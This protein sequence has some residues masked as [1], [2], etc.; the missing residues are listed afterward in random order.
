M[1]VVP[2]RKRYFRDVARMGGLVWLVCLAVLTAF[3]AVEYWEHRDD[4][5]EELLEMVIL[6]A[7]LA[8]AAPLVAWLAWRTSGKLLA[9]LHG[10]QRTVDRIRR[11]E[12]DAQ[13]AAGGADDELAELLESVNGAFEAHRR[14][15]ER[16]ERFS[17]DVSHQ[18]R[19]PLTA[20]R[21]EGE[22]CLGRERTPEAYRDTLG[23]LLEQADRLAKVVDQLLL[24]AK[25][26]VAGP[27]PE[28]RPVDLEGLTWEVADAFRPMCED[29]GAALELEL[30]PVA[31]FGNP[32]WLREAMN[33]LFNNALEY[34]PDPARFRVELRRA[35]DAAEWS[36]EDSGPGIPLEWRERIFDRFQR[37][38]D[39]RDGGS[40][41]GLAIVREVARAHG[42]DL[43][44]EDGALGG[45]RFVMRV[46][47]V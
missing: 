29:R 25:V 44:L 34:T 3:N 47:V 20:M 17:A 24:L 40:G 45:C 38:G 6:F 22:V 2:L 33:N 11:G 8:A 4:G 26:G 32:W 36:L 46:A 30:E 10:L 42:G 13:V 9:P 31:V 14:A 27:R 28:F 7:A 39:A 43:R 1:N 12:L 16:L 15:Q 37:G 18:L 21:T 5:P 41:L 23:K 35:G 19:T